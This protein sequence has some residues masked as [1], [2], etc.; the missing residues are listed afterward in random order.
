MVGAAGD[1][2]Y[3]RSKINEVLRNV[4]NKKHGL[5]EKSSKI[6]LKNLKK[7]WNKTELLE[8]HTISLDGKTYYFKDANNARRNL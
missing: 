3:I 7:Q 8:T 2:I 4:F 1:L 5:Y 6:F